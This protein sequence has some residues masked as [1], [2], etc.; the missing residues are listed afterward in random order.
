[1]TEHFGKLESETLVEENV[2]CRDIVMEIMRF[3]VKQRQITTIIRLLALEMEDI[4]CGRELIA[5]LQE[6]SNGSR[7][8]DTVQRE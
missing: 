4:E 6:F 5:V 7:I 8:T 2:Q 1:M 3:G